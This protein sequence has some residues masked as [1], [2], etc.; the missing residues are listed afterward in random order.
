MANKQTTKPADKKTNETFDGFISALAK[1]GA[2]PGASNM[3][4]QAG[5]QTGRKYSQQELEAAYRGSWIVGAIIDMVA[6]DMT[7]EGI[8]ITGL[9]PDKAAV[10]Q[11]ALIK[12]KIWKAL[13]DGTK[14]GRLYG[15]AAGVVQVDGAD[16]AKP[17]DKKRIA[18][19]GLKGITI[20]DRY[21]IQPIPLRIIEDGPQ[22]G[23]PSFYQIVSGGNKEVH[24]SRVLRFIGLELPWTQ[25]E[26]ESFWG[27]SVLERM[28]DR[29]LTFDTATFSS[30]N[31]M[32]L[33]YIRNINL[34]GFRE[35]MAM[36]GKPQENMQAMWAYNALMQSTYGI[37]IIDAKDTF[38]THSYSFA[39]LSD[40]LVQH[41]QQLC[42]AAGISAT[43]MFGMSPAGMNA[44]GESDTR[45]YYDTIKR[46]QENRLRDHIQVILE[47]LHQSLFGKPLPAEVS[48]AFVPLWQMSQTE[49]A[50]ITGQTT[51][52]I[53]QAVDA[54]L[55]PAH[56]GMA[57]LKQ[58]G[59]TTGVFSNITQEMID[60]AEAENTPPPVTGADLI[61]EG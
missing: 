48:F 49:K 38:N 47:C 25:M 41:G 31:L 32:N 22:M 26:A 27:A 15:G 40:M 46:L 17:L 19:G 13:N 8:E 33:A 44:T 36:G 30:A 14:W 20:Y 59:E 35:V 56:V 21:Q 43:R 50:T 51:T 1:L 3:L 6:E 37:S 11:T 54:G 28:W 24:H 18:S 61:I 29:L 34:D 53:V 16:L 7:R 2:Q 9:D 55:I 45:N 23:L 60:E 42:G 52:A 39:G 10:M 4:S 58:A 57:E 12:L 5:Y